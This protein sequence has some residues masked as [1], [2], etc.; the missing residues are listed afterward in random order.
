MNRLFVLVTLLAGSVLAQQVTI[1]TEPRPHSGPHA[2]PHANRPSHGHRGARG[3]VPFFPYFW[4][5]FYPD[6]GYDYAP[7]EPA[8][9]PAMIMPP[10]ITMVAPAPPPEPARP[11]VHEYKAPAAGTPEDA[12]FEIV[13]TNGSRHEAIAVWVAEGAVHFVTP[14]GGSGRLPLKSVDSRA[15]REANARKGLTLR[16]PAAG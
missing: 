16:L 5:G 4:G 10:P 15:T 1:R 8:T 11:E 9:P 6:N 3:G 12:V 13:G 14:E 2:G 7:P